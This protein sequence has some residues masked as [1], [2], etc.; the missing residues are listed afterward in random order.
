[1]TLHVG[2]AV[3][4]VRSAEERATT[5]DDVVPAHVRTGTGATSARRLAGS[6]AWAG[7]R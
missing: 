5:A 1:M 2:S 4:G 3:G 7:D 6:C